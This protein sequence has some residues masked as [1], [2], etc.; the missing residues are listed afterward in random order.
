MYLGRQIANLNT[1]RSIL[2]TIFLPMERLTENNIKNNI[3]YYFLMIIGNA[4][5]AFVI[6]TQLKNDVL[7]NPRAYFLK[8]HSLRPIYNVTLAIYP[9]LLVYVGVRFINSNTLQNRYLFLIHF[10]LA[11]FLGTR[12]S[13]LEPLL[14]LVVLFYAAKPKLFNV[15]NIVF[16]ITAFLMLT[17]FSVLLRSGASGK[18]VKFGEDFFHG[19]TY[20]DNRDFGWVLAKWNGQ[21]LYGRTYMAGVM[22]VVPRKFSR[23]REKWAI[24][25]YTSK[26]IGYNYKYFAGLRMG[27][28]GEAFLNFG[29]VG[30]GLLGLLLGFVL[31]KLDDV[32]K[33]IFI[34]YGDPIKA[35]A[36]FF[37]W[38][39]VL[40][41]NVSNNFGGFY[42]LVVII[43]L[44][45]GIRQ[46]AGYIGDKKVLAG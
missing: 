46:L 12:T 14:L 37:A 10:I 30:V 15:R 39:F 7:F 11:F 24:G 3:S 44:L 29:I 1:R 45:A 21:Y 38:N 16:I 36:S 5:I 28:F 6:Y 9:L 2:E 19:N 13:L 4:L 25:I 27:F 34:V 22:S 26:V 43:C 33:H 42:S 32:I 41:L 23:F 18:K 17:F 8:D 35:Y 40:C 20:S 31:K